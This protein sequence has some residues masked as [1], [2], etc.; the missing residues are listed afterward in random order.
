[1]VLTAMMLKCCN[2]FITEHLCHIFNSSL[3]SGKVPSDWK[4]SRIT[5]IH[6]KSDSSD[7]SNYH[8]ISLLSLVGSTLERILHPAL[9]AHVL[10]NGVTSDN[11][12]GFRSKSST[13][14][15]LLSACN[16]WHK[17]MEEGGINVAV[18]LDLA[19]AF[20]T[21]QHHRVIKALARAGVSGHSGLRVTSW[22]GCDSWE[23]WVCL[24]RK[25]V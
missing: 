8:P 22:T 4:V 1:M 2:P 20:D 18:F 17:T 12:F 3:A 10:V 11:Q 16:F 7:V 13:Q 19:K 25:S 24:P 21:I 23:F 6:K 15:A 9:I 14:E 5:S